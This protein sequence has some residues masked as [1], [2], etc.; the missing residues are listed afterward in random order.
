MYTYRQTRKRLLDSIDQFLSVGA[1]FIQVLRLQFG[2][3]KCWR[4]FHSKQ[5]SKGRA[6]PIKYDQFM[7][8]WLVPH[9]MHQA[10]G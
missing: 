8:S 7:M 5:G 9:T 2:R 6:Q 3:S 10:R 1:F 4:G